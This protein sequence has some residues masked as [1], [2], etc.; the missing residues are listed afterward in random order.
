MRCR[1]DLLG[2]RLWTGTETNPSGALPEGGSLTVALPSLTDAQL[3][4]SYFLLRTDGNSER[5]GADPKTMTILLKGE[6]SANFASYPSTCETTFWHTRSFW[7]CKTKATFRFRLSL[8]CQDNGS[9]GPRNF[10]SGENRRPD[11]CD[12]CFNCF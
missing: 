7:R 9:W 11:E 10:R 8:E 5:C 4:Q 3:R 6:S 2:R 1:F 12:G